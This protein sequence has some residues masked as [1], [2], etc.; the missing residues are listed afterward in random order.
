MMNRHKSQAKAAIILLIITMILCFTGCSFEGY[1]WFDT[2]Y[3]F[4]KAIIKMPDGEIITVEVAQWA[5]AEGEQLTITGKD[6]KQYLVSS[7]N[8]ILLEDA[9]E[10]DG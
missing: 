2:N 7:I 4:D 5:D 9:S 6:G 8:C 10:A 1:D 3:H